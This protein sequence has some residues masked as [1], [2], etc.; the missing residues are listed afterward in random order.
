M[1]VAYINALGGCVNICLFDS[2]EELVE[3]EPRYRS[4]TKTYEDAVRRARADI[5]EWQDTWRRR[6]DYIDG[7]AYLALIPAK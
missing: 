5:T 2:P 3:F 7:E 4:E 6:E 1:Y